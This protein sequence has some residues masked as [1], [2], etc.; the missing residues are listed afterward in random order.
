MTDDLDKLDAIAKAGTCGEWDWDENDCSFGSLH[1]E[2]S[3][4]V[5]VAYAR[6]DRDAEGPI[7]DISPEDAKHIAA[8]SPD[9]VLRL[10]AR[11][12]EAEREIR[13][14]RCHEGVFE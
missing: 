8:F 3:H 4:Y 9:V 12:R 14:H 13:D 10:M 6:I 11:L 2:R 7:I 5:T 1:D